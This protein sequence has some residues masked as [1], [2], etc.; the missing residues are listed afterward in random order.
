MLARGFGWGD[1]TFF[2]VVVIFVV[3]LTEDGRV[4]KTKKGSRTENVLYVLELEVVVFSLPVLQQST[5]L[6]C[7]FPEIVERLLK[8][9]LE[10]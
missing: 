9:E 7:V 8:F 4:S 6:L 5:I 10:A 3:I 1:T 2:L